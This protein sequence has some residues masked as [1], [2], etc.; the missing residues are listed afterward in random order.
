MTKLERTVAAARRRLTLNQWL[1][2]VTAALLIAAGAFAVCVMVVRFYDVSAPLGVLGAAAG[3]A[4]VIVA[5]IWT[6]ATRVDE[7]SAAAALD[8]AAG[9]RERLSS[10]LYC[11]EGS[12][13]FEQAVTRDAES[14]AGSLTPTKHLPL[15]WPPRLAGMAVALAVCAATFL[16]PTGLLLGDKNVSDDDIVEAERTAAVIK[17]QTESIQR[18]AKTNAEL[19]KLAEDLDK[20]GDAPEGRLKT[21]ADLRQR[22]LKHLDKMEDVLKQQRG[23]DKFERAREFKKMLRS[24]KPPKTPDSEISKLAK[25]LRDG[26]FKA[27]QS[28]IQKLQEKLKE[29]DKTQ[30]ADKALAL[31]KQL[32]ALAKNLE[33]LADNK[34]LKEQLQ[35]AGIKKEDLE[36]MLKNLTKEDI[37]KIKKQLQKQGLSQKK[38]D[39]MAKQLQKRQA[40]GE[41]SSKLADALQQ[42]AGAMG[43]GQMGQAS[44]GLQSAADQMSS[45]EMLEQEMSQIDSA[46]ADMQGARGSLS[47]P[48]GQ[49]NGTGQKSGSSCSSCNGSGSQSGNQGGNGRGGMGKN[50]G[51]GRGG[52]AAEEQTAT[53]FVKHRDK[54]K[55]GSGAIIG[56]FLVDGEQYKGDVSP[57]VNEL[58]KTANQDATDAIDHARIPRRYHKAVKEYFSDLEREL[59]PAKRAKKPKKDQAKTNDD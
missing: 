44:E 3:L 39:E 36:R 13:P 43:G 57:A 53:A 58:V 18:Y 55:T 50:P 48:C 5:T 47:K 38:I 32:D 42:A 11:Q 33:A 7:P 26:D 12:D 20:L 6:F 25:S 29:L 14:A 46:M 34:K 10:G 24:L 16:I 17:K 15:R 4:G 52:I 22:A 41:M 27:A 23:D 40:A 28:Q 56:Q 51:Q 59:G 19:Q 35:Q 30:D 54:V 37:E 8:E 21:P 49:C 1:T 9:L 2:H 31:Q 45:M